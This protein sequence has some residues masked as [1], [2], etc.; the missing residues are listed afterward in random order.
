MRAVCRLVGAG[1][2]VALVMAGVSLAMA[3]GSDP[4]S[5]PWSTSVS[6]PVV[7]P[8]AGDA[9][10]S[11]GQ[12]GGRSMGATMALAWLHV[13]QRYLSVITIS[14]CPLHPSCSNYSMQ[15]V[16]RCGAVRGIVMTADRLIHEWDEQRYAPIIVIS[17]R[18]LYFDPVENNDIWRRDR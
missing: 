14:H 4:I 9:A 1:S 11:M 18:R 16:R 12:G 2:A 15:A 3:Q 13:Y 17:G 7:S 6:S 8:A 5:E 10:R